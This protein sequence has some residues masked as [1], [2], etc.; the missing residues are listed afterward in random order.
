MALQGD[1]KPKALAIW[2]PGK[3]KPEKEKFTAAV[4]SRLELLA[5]LSPQPR[6]LFSGD[7]RTPGLLRFF[8]SPAVPAFRRYVAAS[9][10]F[11][12]QPQAQA[13]LTK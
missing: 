10:L 8:C 7:F 5:A 4:C 1:R 11:N 2:D 6:A 3:P 9:F 12:R 13:P